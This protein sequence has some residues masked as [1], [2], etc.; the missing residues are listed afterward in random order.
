MLRGTVRDAATLSLSYCA[1]NGALIHMILRT[2]RRTVSC[3]NK[4]RH[5]E[6][7]YLIGSLTVLL[8]MTSLNS[9][10]ARPYGRPVGNSVIALRFQPH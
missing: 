9:R 10:E 3:V 4:E 1:A 5:P 2:V 7:A 6:Q 8:V